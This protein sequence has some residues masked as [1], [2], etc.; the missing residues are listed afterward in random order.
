MR[1]VQ[2]KILLIDTEGLVDED[3]HDILSDAGYRVRSVASQ[4][5]GL[6]RILDHRYDV[7][8][9]SH[10]VATLA[11]MVRQIRS[12]NT[13]TPVI[14]LLP[15][16]HLDA[17]VQGLVAGASGYAVLERG[18]SALLKYEIEKQILDG[19]S[20]SA[21]PVPN[22]KP[23]TTRHK[24]RTG[25]ND[26][27]LRALIA[28]QQAGFRVQRRMMPE[29]PCML[30]EVELNHRIYPSLI[31][32]G[33]FVDYFALPDGRVLFYLADVSGHGASS[34]FVTVLL[35]SLSRH[36]LRRFSQLKLQDTGAI[37]KWMNKELLLGELEHHL[38]LFLGIID[39]D[40]ATLEYSNAAHFPGAILT[41]A[42]TTCYL[43]SGGRPLGLF[44]RVTYETRQVSLPQS[45]HLVLFSDGVLEIMPQGTLKDKESQLLSLI[46]C[47]VR[48][49]DALAEKLGMEATGLP[50][51]VAVLTVSAD[52]QARS[53]GQPPGR[54]KHKRAVASR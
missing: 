40:A 33:D 38:T 14:L 3:I 50:D 9:L 45:W 15:P 17:A 29:T 23:R 32:S 16:E 6:A 11:E 21:H 37:L 44:K 4:S 5:K 8:L 22:R 19:H 12:H 48:N 10:C 7:I 36:L 18:A 42:D 34:A 24:E 1:P 31:L 47:G 28:D 20:S 41:G 25:P 43:Q 46:E 49:V 2:N 39:A 30:G 13:T 27:R 52:P 51:D 53:A 54:K 35:K 26:Q